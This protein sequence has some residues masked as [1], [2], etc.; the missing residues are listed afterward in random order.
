M[1]RQNEGAYLP[2][3]LLAGLICQSVARTL[4]LKVSQGVI[5]LG[6]FALPLI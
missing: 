5:A 1:R 3:C 4:G 6:L 2:P